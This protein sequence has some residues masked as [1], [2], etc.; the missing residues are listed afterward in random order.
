MA[1]MARCQ[2]VNLVAPHNT[3]KYMMVG[4]LMRNTVQKLEIK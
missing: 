4:G 1:T 2:R 3:V